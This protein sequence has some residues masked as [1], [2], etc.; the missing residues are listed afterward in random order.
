M[1]RHPGEYEPLRAR[2]SAWV[3]YLSCVCGCINAVSL[4]GIFEVP[5][6]HL[7]GTTTRMA[8][9]VAGA[10]TPGY[11]SV[12]HFAIVVCFGLGAFFSGFL[13]AEPSVDGHWS[14]IRLDHPN[15]RE[16]RWQH[17]LLLSASMLCLGIAHTLVYD[18]ASNIPDYSADRFL[19]RPTFGAAILFTAFSSAVLNCLLTLGGSQFITLRSHLTGTLSDIFSAMG[20]CLR[21]RDYRYLWKVRLY[22]LNF[23]FF[24]TGAVI[25]AN[26][27]KQTFG[28]SALLVPI[29]MLAPLWLLGAALLIVRHTRLGRINRDSGANFDMALTETPSALDAA[30]L[31]SGATPLVSDSTQPQPSVEGSVRDSDRP[32]KTHETEGFGLTIFDREQTMRE[33]ERAD[34]APPTATLA[35]R[36]DAAA[37]ASLPPKE[38]DSTHP[39]HFAW[40]TYMS[41]VGGA[42]NAIALQGIFQQTVTHVTGLATSFGM[43]LQ[44]PPAPTSRGTKSYAAGECALIILA[45][46]AASFVCGVILTSRQGAP[47]SP[48]YIVLKMDYP[49]AGSWRL[50]H[51]VILSICIASLCASYGLAHDFTGD[52]KNYALSIGVQLSANAAFVVACLFDA[53]ASGALNALM[54]HGHRIVLRATHVT[55][56]ITDIFMGLGFALRSRSLRFM[57]RLRLL[58][59]A[60]VSF[61]AGG[62]AGSLV[63]SSAFGVSAVAVPAILLAP[64]W[65]AGLVLLMVQKRHQS[66]ALAGL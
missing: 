56:C 14:A 43:T 46:G 25:G 6:T 7:T 52:D 41:F 32:S 53:F 42:I 55:G 62:V 5:S 59:I 11:S 23:C 1:Q 9:S 48:N 51:Q 24:V 26:A 44:Y 47:A 54:S 38:S 34:S 58:L 20:F 12:D 64:F 18:D 40:L 2:N 29:I 57:G 19:Q 4:K 37:L 45:F 15:V 65:A 17:Q 8:M 10:P 16:W 61:F 22:A 3:S 33:P 35:T 60:Y 13:L 63:F 31:A 50:Q 66:Q 39:A 27:F 28:Y 30:A 21:S 36:T 49:S